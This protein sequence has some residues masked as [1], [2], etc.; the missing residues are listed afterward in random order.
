ME[1]LQ[2]NEQ[3]LKQTHEIQVELLDQVDRI[4]RKHDIKYMICGGT[5]IGAVR[6]KGFIPWDDDVDVRMERKE[7]ERF[8]KVC[9]QELD[10]DKFFFQT[11]KTDKN[12]PWYFGKLRYNY[13]RYVR[14]GQDHLNMNDGIFLDI[15][16]TDG[17][18]NNSVA[19]TFVL[20][21]CKLLKK[22]LYSIVGSV[23]E[24]NPIKR[25]VYKVMNKYPKRLVYKSFDAMAKKY[26]DPRYRCV[27]DYSFPSKL[28]RPEFF[29]RKWVLELVELEFENRNYYATAF[30]D[31]WLTIG[32]G[33]YM[34]LPPP[35]KRH[36]N[37][38]IVIFSIDDENVQK[39]RCYC[40]AEEHHDQI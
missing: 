8:C 22:M 39:D 14:V 19:R 12:Y 1:V 21:K 17:I 25:T 28:F 32:Y 27:T 18:P 5:L 30:Y 31:K 23:H 38:D 3:Q 13:S 15:F 34:E 40:F 4:C 35:E 29:Q 26:S 16:P 9:Q 11:H 24:K 10:G 7:Y 33:N 2:L 37:N 6:H 36:G 20:I